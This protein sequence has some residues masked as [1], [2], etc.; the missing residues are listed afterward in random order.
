MLRQ[1]L[2]TVPDFSLLEKNRVREPIV[3]SFDIKLITPM[4]G[5]SAIAGRVDP[6]RPVN[7]KTIRGHLRFWWR[8]C[9]AGMYCNAEELFNAEEAI[10]GSTETPS[11]V[12]VSISNI[13]EG[14]E[15]AW[16]EIKYDES[17]SKY[18]GRE[19]NEGR[20]YPAYAL[21]P[22]QGEMPSDDIKSV[23]KQPDRC[24]KDISF[25]LNVSCAVK[26]QDDVLAA[27]R[28]WI[29][30]GGVGSR[31]RRGC[32]SLYCSNWKEHFGKLIINP[33]EK[34]TFLPSLSLGRLA[35]NATPFC[36][37]LDQAT[38]LI[39]KA[40]GSGLR[41]WSDAVRLMS[42]FRQKECFAR[43]KGDQSHRPGK[44]LWPEADS[45]RKLADCIYCKHKP[46]NTPI[47]FY[48]RADLGLPIL[49]H[50]IGCTGC[51]KTHTIGLNAN[52]K[53][54]MASPI[55][56]K[57]LAISETEV[58]PIV[59]LLNAP[60]VWESG[61]PVLITSDQRSKTLKIQDIDDMTKSSFV[62]PMNGQ[63]VRHAFMAY[64]KNNILGVQEVI[65]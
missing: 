53:G 61:K 4:F 42:D 26:L 35:P 28:A 55:I 64:A 3:A 33:V 63:N 15:V 47:D 58:Y 60:H 52:A 51:P 9:V 11:A 62:R 2:L 39:G 30:F 23:K 14:T 24:W 50:F 17:K 13:N 6:E 1:P 5:G 40:N 41:A 43:N 48:P 22:F 21:F 12:D 49:F 31:T 32:G 45:I 19:T 57:P 16:Y 65:F 59:L 10:W 20:Q 8:A 7:A 18:V 29:L 34:D 38:L 25:T 54:R 46:T 27:L 56:L 37:I 36:P 44:S